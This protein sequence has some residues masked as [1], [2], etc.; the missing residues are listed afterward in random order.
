MSGGVQTAKLKQS[1]YYNEFHNSKKKNRMDF[2]KNK[3]IGRDD[4][5]NTRKKEKNNLIHQ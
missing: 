1:V 3:H 4:K 5:K 2:F